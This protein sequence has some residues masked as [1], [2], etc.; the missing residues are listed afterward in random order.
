[1]QKGALLNIIGGSKGFKTLQT[2]NKVLLANPN[3]FAVLCANPDI[4]ALRESFIVSQLLTEYQIHYHNQGDFLIDEKYIIEVGG[5][6]KDKKQIKELNNAYLAIDD[7][8]SG[9]EN[10][11]PLWLFGFLY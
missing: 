4:G 11:I 5:K 3:L 1:M 8:E 6:S 10:I 2:P 7:I 9:Y